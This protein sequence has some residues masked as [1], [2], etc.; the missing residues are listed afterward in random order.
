MLGTKKAMRKVLKSH[1]IY[2]KMEI[3]C[4]KSIDDLIIL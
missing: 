4:V 2:I 1:Y 3:V